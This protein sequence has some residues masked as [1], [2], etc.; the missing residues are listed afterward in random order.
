MP[1]KITR[2]SNRES[3]TVREIDRAIARWR[4][5]TPARNSDDGW[6]HCVMA[7]RDLQLI[8]NELLEDCTCDEKYNGECTEECDEE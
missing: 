5:E 1:V 8:R 6:D 4:A 7:I 2:L 3:R